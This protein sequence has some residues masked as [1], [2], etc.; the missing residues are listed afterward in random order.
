[1]EVRGARPSRP[2]IDKKWRKM[3]LTNPVI[4]SFT[5]CNHK[6]FPRCSRNGDC[7]ADDTRHS[8]SFGSHCVFGCPEARPRG[9]G[10][11][12]GW[13]SGD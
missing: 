8:T 9:F 4:R 6:N 2:R 7:T 3:V 11:K 13:L 12:M 1:M 5:A 10:A